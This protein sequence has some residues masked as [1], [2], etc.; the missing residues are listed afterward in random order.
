M[1]QEII[2]VGASPNDGQGDPIRTAFIKTNT[3]FGELFSRTQDSPPITLVGSIGDTAGMV[4][5]DQEYYYYCFADFDGSS[6]IW[7]EVPNALT[8]NV[9][10]I[11]AT[12]DVT[13]NAFIGDGSQLTGVIASAPTSIQNGNGVVA[14]TSAGNIYFSTGY[15][16]NVASLTSFFNGSSVDT[17]FLVSGNIH[18]TTGNVI[19]RSIRATNAGNIVTLGNGY[20]IFGYVTCNNVF[21]ANTISLSGNVTSNLNLSANLAVAGNVAINGSITSNATVVGNVSAGNVASL[22]AV[23]A[24]GN[25]SGAYIIG[26]GG[27][28]S[29]ITAISNV[30]V[31]QIANGTT[32]ISIASSGGNARIDSGG[33]ANIAVFTSTGANIGGYLNAIGN[34]S[35]SNVDTSGRILAVGNITGGNLAT[36]GQVSAL[37]NIIGANI[38]AVGNVS[39]ANLTT[40]G[41]A[42]VGTLVVT[43]T[44]SF[45]GNITSSIN[46][47]GVVSAG[48][49]SATGTITGGSLLSVAGNITG[50]NVITGSGSTVLNNGLTTTGNVTASSVITTNGVTS[51]GNI[52]GGNILT[53]GILSAAGNV[54]GGNLTIATIT[55][56][57]NLSVTGAANVIGNIYSDANLIANVAVYTPVISHTGPN[58][59]GNIG[60]VGS[61]FNYVF[62]NTFA[63]LATS[64]QYADLAECYLADEHYAP[65]TVLSFGGSAEL[66]ISLTDQDPTIAGVVSTKPAYRMN[67]ALEGE[68]VVALALTGRVPCRVQGQVSRGD[69]MVSAGNG[70]AR[71]EKN[72]V[73]GSVIGKALESFD[74]EIGTIEVVVG[75]L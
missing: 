28:L 39:G 37:G 19:G 51:T 26:D 27:L 55:S 60:A 7:R 46:V 23:S 45:A 61:I 36:G 74:G 57:G 4:A 69:M 12:G 63:G 50:S 70:R 30:A 75:R 73:I 52:T 38:T 53:S 24:V 41:T 62:A 1:A 32:I 48:N 13:A 10:T 54:T 47:I 40:T 49:L 67:S 17:D 22:G 31:S 35:G 71:A 64:A 2:N 66:T 5:Y 15:L 68:H 9:T 14:I 25:V 34:V 6:I 3:N 65:G 8:A 58:A 33:T 59:T 42:N 18:A 20:G 72:P 21:S 56:S 16:P 11:N 44:S 29:N 43:Q